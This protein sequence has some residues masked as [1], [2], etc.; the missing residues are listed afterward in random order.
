MTNLNPTN[1]KPLSSYYVLDAFDRIAEVGGNW[2]ETAAD[3]D[4]SRANKDYVI[5]GGMRDFV[6]GDEVITFLNTLFFWCRFEKRTY[7]T[8]YRCD[9]ADTARLFRMTVAPH[10]DDTLMV[11]HRLISQNVRPP[12]AQAKNQ[13]HLHGPRCSMCCRYNIGSDWIDPFSTLDHAYQATS[14]VFCPNCRV[15]LSAGL[16]TRLDDLENAARHRL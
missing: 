6:H 2:G 12:S 4:Q 14:H 8:L 10:T 11:A 1:S 3:A 13:P 9:A 7:E 15:R 5:G 16:A